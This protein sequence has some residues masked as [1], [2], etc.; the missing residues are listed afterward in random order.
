MNILTEAKVYKNK[1]KSIINVS[2]E[3]ILLWE[4]RMFQRNSCKRKD[5]AE[6]IINSGILPITAS[7]T[8]IDKNN[9]Y[10]VLC[11]YKNLNILNK[12][13]FSFMRKYK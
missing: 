5:L 7:D 9:F 1:V 10:T 2:E 13:L 6:I 11:K 4:F 8:S 12:K 3:Q